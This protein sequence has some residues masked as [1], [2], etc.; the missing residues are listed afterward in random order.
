M[1][2]E[3]EDADWVVKLKDRMWEDLEEG[4]DPGLRILFEA[5]VRAL[6]RLD[7]PTDSRW[8]S[9]GG[10]TVGLE[11]WTVSIS[12]TT[13]DGLHFFVDIVLAIAGSGFRTVWE[14]DGTLTGR[15]LAAI[16]G[17]VVRDPDLE[18]RVELPKQPFPEWSV[19]LAEDV[20]TDD[21]TPAWLKTWVMLHLP[22]EQKND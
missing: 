20:M 15:A 7:I 18:A 9:F 17:Q 14:C 13:R 4:M 11:D 2:E 8:D 3:I 22:A 6:K 5:T 1:T 19:Q 12:V 21:A 10:A 16:F